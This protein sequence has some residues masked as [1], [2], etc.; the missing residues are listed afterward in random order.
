MIFLP[1]NKSDHKGLDKIPMN[2]EEA[3][4]RLANASFPA[5]QCAVMV[6]PLSSSSGRNDAKTSIETIIRI[7]R[8]ARIETPQRLRTVDPGITSDCSLP[9]K[10]PGSSQFRTYSRLSRDL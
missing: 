6:I 8:I 10:M 5:I 1:L 2:P 3:V 9:E 4:A 7:V